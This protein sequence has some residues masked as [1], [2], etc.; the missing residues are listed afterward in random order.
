MLLLQNI[1][2]TTGYV[3]IHMLD[4]TLKISREMVDNTDIVPYWLVFGMFL[5]S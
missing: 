5:D 4:Y 1:Y 2:R 3:R